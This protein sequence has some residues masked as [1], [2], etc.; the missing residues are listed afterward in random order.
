M[1]SSGENFHGGFSF[2]GI[3][4]S[5]V[6]GVRCL[7]VFMYPNQRFGEVCGHNMH[8]LLHANAL[9]Y[10]M[11]LCVIALNLNCQ[12]S[13]LGYR[14]KLNSMLHRS[15]KLQNFDCVLKKGSK[16]HSSLCQCKPQNEAALMSR[17]ILAGEHRCAAGL[18][19]APPSLQDR[20]LLYYTTGFLACLHRKSQTLSQKSQ[21]SIL[22][23][24]HIKHAQ[25]H[26]K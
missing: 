22:R 16:T 21:I 14:R 11:I 17:R 12:C 19:G 5:S 1:L 24:I 25:P 26:T 7:C 9:P 18:A 10:F 4:W 6:C 8:I 2:L 23:H 13:K 15:S 20:I 3:W